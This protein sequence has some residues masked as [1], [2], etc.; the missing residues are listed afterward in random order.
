MTDFSGGNTA[1]IFCSVYYGYIILSVD[2]P[3]FTSHEYDQ[4][5]FQTR[6]NTN[7]SSEN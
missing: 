2:T 7:K 1:P 3:N 5:V 6:L 4:A